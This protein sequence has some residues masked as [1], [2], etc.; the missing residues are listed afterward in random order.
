MS[1]LPFGSPQSFERNCLFRTIVSRAFRSSPNVYKE[2]APHPLL[3][4]RFLAE[5]C[6]AID[7]LGSLTWLKYAT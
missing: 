3:L 6:H 4:V 7:S 1:N 2:R 5:R